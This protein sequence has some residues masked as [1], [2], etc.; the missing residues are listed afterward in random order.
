MNSIK[1]VFDETCTNFVVDTRLLAKIRQYEHRFVNKN[2]HHINFFGGVLMGVNPVRFTQEDRQRWFDDIIGTD[3]LLIK[4][5]IHA[6]PT[7][8]ATRV[9]STDIMNLSC[10]WVIHKFLSDKRL[11]EK[12]REEG[13]LL[14][15]QIMNYK[16]FTST[17]TGWFTYNANPVVAQ[18]TYALLTKKFGL[19]MAGSWGALIRNRSYDIVK[20]GGLH[21]KTLMDFYPDERIVNVANDTWGRVKSILKYIRDVFT[22]AQ[23]MPEYQIQTTGNTIVLDGE[24]RLRDRTRAITEYIDYTLGILH[25][26]HSF[27]K[28]DLLAI[29]M[30]VMGNVPIR[31]MESVLEYM[32]NNSSIKADKE[33]AEFVRHVIEHAVNYVTHNPGVMRNRSDLAELIR[34]MRG[35][36]TAAKT[37]DPDIIKI[38]YLGERIAERGGKTRNKQVVV[39]LRNAI[40][41]YV[42][43]RTMVMHHYR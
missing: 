4:P 36:Y 20:K 43:L 40:A 29:I 19:K 30:K 37:T 10:L 12:Q 8:V 1:N 27:I 21:Y 17:L 33:V 15:A 23:N 32:I 28:K 14:T 31:N 6:L 13:A 25:D 39:A 41:L 16:F 3:E 34:R 18:T 22:T 7:I 5:G 42:V 35:L 26:K 11:P 24:V 38:R 2:E 9:V